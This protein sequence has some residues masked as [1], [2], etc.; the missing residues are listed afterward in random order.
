LKQEEMPYPA[1]VPSH[2]KNEEFRDAWDGTEAAWVMS[3]PLASFPFERWMTSQSTG[4]DS[5]LAEF[6]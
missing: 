3:F 1:P 4:K 5:K 6:N 2:L